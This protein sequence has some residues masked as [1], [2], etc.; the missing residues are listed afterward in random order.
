ML[1]KGG[2]LIDPANQQEGQADLLIEKGKIVS[3]GKNLSPNGA[4]VVELDGLWVV[5]GLIDIH[6][7]FR[8]PGREDKETIE[9]GSRAAAKGGFT[10]VCPMANTDPV[11][12]TRGIVEF[13]LEEAQRA[14]LVRIYPVGAVT[15]GQKGEELAELGELYENG[16]V[17]FSDD[18]HPIQ[19]SLVMR[20]ALEYAGMYG[21]PIIVH[22]ED[23]FLF[24][25]IQAG[26]DPG[27]PVV[28]AG[29]LGMLV[30]LSLLFYLH[31]RRLWV[32]ALPEG[33][34]ASVHVAGYSS[35]GPRDF[36][37]E[38]A[39][40]VAELRGRVQPAAEDTVSVSKDAMG[41]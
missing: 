6:V 25:G 40:R 39:A 7:H 35:R 2:T 23:P 10:S 20:R 28:L 21:L 19:N 3:V 11:V 17:A 31:R 36:R 9:S 24:S 33:T 27:Y 15:K 18:G 14:S 30:G 22:A 37:G 29:S 1:L 32:L 26:F 5:P 38:F 16:C 34:G 4:K 13:I 12:D 41:E 8:Q